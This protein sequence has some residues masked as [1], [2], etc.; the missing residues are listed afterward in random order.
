MKPSR[1]FAPMGTQDGLPEE[2]RMK[3]YVES[4]FMD[5]CRCF[6]YGEVHTPV[7]EYGELF[8][9]GVGPVTDIVENELYTFTDKQGDSFALRPEGTTGI[10]RAVIQHEMYKK[11]PLKL[12]YK[13]TCYRQE[14]PEK[15]R[16]REFHQIGAECYGSAKPQADAEIITLAYMALK[17]IGVDRL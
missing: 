4:V 12:C 2:M 17:A 5:Q 8:E 15:G 6:G 7:F 9:R 14:D 13:I 3:R 11:L 16:L 1:I 10:A